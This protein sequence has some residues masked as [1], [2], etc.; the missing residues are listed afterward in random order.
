MLVLP[1]GQVSAEDAARS[2]IRNQQAKM[3]EFDQLESRLAAGNSTAAAAAA[4]GAEGEAAGEGEG[5]DAA[6]GA[7]AA[8]D[9]LDLLNPSTM[10]EQESFVQAA[11]SFKGTLK[12]YQLRGLNW[13]RTT[14]SPLLL[15]L[16]LQA[17]GV[18]APCSRDVLC[19]ISRAVVCFSSL[20]SCS[21]CTSK[22][23]T[24]F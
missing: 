17:A 4:S 10:P 9:S 21:I 6:G 14:T 5:G 22:A 7:V 3:Q 15:R 18:V 12:S 23:S 2:Y 13:V 24:A 8:G 19:L 11:S 20:C 16:R 1:G